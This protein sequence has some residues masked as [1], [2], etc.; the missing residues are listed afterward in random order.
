MTVS[1][2]DNQECCACQTGGF[3]MVRGW[4]ATGWAKSLVESRT[5]QDFII[6]ISKLCSFTTSCTCTVHTD[7]FLH[8]RTCTHAHQVDSPTA[9]QLVTMT[10][11]SLSEFVGCTINGE[12]LW[13]FSLHSWSLG[14]TFMVP[15]PVRLLWVCGH[16]T[17]LVLL[18]RWYPTP[19]SPIFQLP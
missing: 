4:W 14:L 8:P 11:S 12:S 1:Q 9:I 6:F 17:F 3:Y 10:P 18:R 5:A 2:P 19:P 13:V 7:Q 15:V 16:V